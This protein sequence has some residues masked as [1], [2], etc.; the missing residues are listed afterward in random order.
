VQPPATTN[1]IIVGES[2]AEGFATTS[3][4]C[5]PQLMLPLLKKPINLFVAATS[6]FSYTNWMSNSN[7]VTGLLQPGMENIVALFGCCWNEIIQGATPAQAYAN[8]QM[9]VSSWRGAAPSMGASIKVIGTGQHQI[10]NS[11]VP[12]AAQNSFSGLLGS[13]HSFLDG[14]FDLWSDPMIGSSAN[15][16]NTTYYIGDHL[17]AP[18]AHLIIAEGLATRFNAVAA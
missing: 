6:G 16:S 18:V 12:T 10:A 9:L 17:T 5:F 3:N 11:T 8:M 4:Q 13:G 15:L 14:Y 2:V 7:V 1:L